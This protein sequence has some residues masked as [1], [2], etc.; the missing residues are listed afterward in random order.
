MP[1]ASLSELYQFELHFE[2]VAKDFLASAAGIAAFTT[3]DFD[4][5][6]T[7]RLEVQFTSGGAELP[8]DDPITAVPALAE[9]EFRKYDAALDVQII[10]EPGA[11]QTR[12]NHFAYVGAVRVALLRSSTN[13]DTDTLPFY[14]VRWIRPSATDRQADGDFEITI[15]SYELKFGIRVDAFPTS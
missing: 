12:A 2:D 11:G 6:T 15:L 10:T 3:F 4:D 14:G 5:F 7:P 13:W 9:G 8:V 1:A